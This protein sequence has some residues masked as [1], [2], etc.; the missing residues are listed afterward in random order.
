MQCS[1]TQEFRMPLKR[2]GPVE[3]FEQTVQAIIISVSYRR[4]W[5]VQYLPTAVDMFYVH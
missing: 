1:R 3:G 2:Q 4:F 5:I